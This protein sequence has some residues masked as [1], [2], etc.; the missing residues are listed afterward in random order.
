MAKYKDY[1]SKLFFSNYISNKNDTT[2]DIKNFK[3]DFYNP[4]LQRL[5]IENEYNKHFKNSKRELSNY[6]IEFLDDFFAFI[7]KDSQPND[8]INQEDKLVRGIGSKSKRK[9]GRR[10]I[11]NDLEPLYEDLIPILIKF[12][13]ALSE[14]DKG[15]NFLDS[16]PIFQE[17]IKKQYLKSINNSISKIIDK[18]EGLPTLFFNGIVEKFTPSFKELTSSFMKFVN[19]F[20]EYKNTNFISVSEDPSKDELMNAI[21]NALSNLPLISE[22]SDIK[23][24]NHQ[25]NP[26]KNKAN[27]RNNQKTLINK[28]EERNNLIKD[29]LLSIGVETSADFQYQ[30]DCINNYETLARLFPIIYNNLLQDGIP[31]VTFHF[32]DIN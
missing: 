2:E 12:D 28:K 18:L 5:L 3:S 11:N 6:D 23:Q 9:N 21:G 26:L 22:S 8:S 17:A 24:L 15:S 13:K 14:N 27:Y 30:E 7:D 1:F 20:Y 10:I 16:H 4:I 31:N 32:N 29:K 25:I 19:E